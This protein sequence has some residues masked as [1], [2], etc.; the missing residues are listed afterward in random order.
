M[1]KQIK[2]FQSDIKELKI[3]QQDVI[4]NQLKI[5]CDKILK[6][7]LFERKQV[8]FIKNI[9]EIGRELKN[10]TLYH[11]SKKI[12]MKEY[13]YD[14]VDYFVHRHICISFDN[15]FELS[16]YVSDDN[17]YTTTY[18]I[19]IKTKTHEVEI[20]TDI[21]IISDTLDAYYKIHEIY[22]ELELKN[23]SKEKFITFLTKT[24]NY[25]MNLEE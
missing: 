5:I 23:V 17:T 25:M 24:F 9:K 22:D 6:K 13:I 21:P 3:D 8:Q 15:Q 10:N 14:R 1:D 12:I 4:A 16:F 20:D 7:N 2:K 11:L 18:N 19:N